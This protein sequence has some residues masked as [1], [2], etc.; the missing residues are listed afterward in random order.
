MQVC[1]PRS[2]YERTIPIPIKKST[3][4]TLNYEFSDNQY[5]LKQNIFDPTKNS[6]PNDFMIKLQ[7]RM[8]VYESLIMNVD[9]EDSE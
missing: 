3:R 8:S 5:S 6:P 7:K 2:I 4:N 1:N 9:N